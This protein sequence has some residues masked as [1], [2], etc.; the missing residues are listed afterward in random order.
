MTS[1]RDVV[2]EATPTPDLLVESEPSH[3]TQYGPVRA[4]AGVHS[5]LVVDDDR[6]IR[7][8]LTSFFDRQGLEVEAVGG[9][10]EALERFRARPTDLVLLD[11]VLPDG[12]GM[13]VLEALPTQSVP[14]ILLTG[15]GEVADAVE[16][17]R[18]G[19]E[20]FLTKPVDLT[21][22]SQAV[23][24]ALEKANLRQERSRLRESV[25]GPLDLD[26]LGRSARMRRL[27]EQV[28]LAA[29]RT[30]AVTLVSGE[31]GTGKGWL[32]RLLHELGPRAGGPFVEVNAGALRPETMVAELFGEETAAGDRRRGLLESASGGT[33]F[34]DNI[35]D[36]SP[37]LQPH[38][39][40]V[41]E[42]GRF[43]RSGGKKDLTADVR[44]VAATSRDLAPEV[45]AGRFREDLYYRLNVLPLHLPPLRER[46]A[47]DRKTLVKGIFQRLRQ[48]FPAPPESIAPNALEH[49]VRYRWP[50]NVRELRNVLERT[51]ILAHSKVRVEPDDLPP[52]VT[53]DPEEAPDQA[54]GETPPQS[55]EAMERKHI[56]EALRY[57][58]GNRTRTAQDLGIARAT[59]LNKIKRYGLE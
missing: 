50:G 34:L 58:D 9:A 36:L 13:E 55:L 24:R 17:M 10:T 40:G 3:P 18:L 2:A 38:L 28:R 32:A 44:F 47:E 16:A 31:V 46:S 22:L 1:H 45:A 5:I 53:A 27:A 7:E 15:K 57:R 43:R 6:A 59:L 29:N 30:Q 42:S 4:S 26:G 52:E 12:S 23:D 20:N 39:L 48:D 35:G 21:H 25:S 33:L 54:D 14:V 51:L 11:L 19:A 49:L 41:L 8:A 56:R 37:D